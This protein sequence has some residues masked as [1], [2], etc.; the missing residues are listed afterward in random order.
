MFTI[1]LSD[2]AD[3]TMP[4]TICYTGILRRMDLHA[5]SYI[6]H[7]KHRETSQYPAADSHEGSELMCMHGRVE[8]LSSA[9][10]VALLRYLGT[11]QRMRHTCLIRPLSSG[12]VDVWKLHSNPW[13]HIDISYGWWLRGK[14]TY[15]ASEPV[16]QASRSKFHLLY[17]QLLIIEAI[18]EI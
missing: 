11:R 13:V 9:T 6:S 3:R 4:D 16:R 2:A 14:I 12:C 17:L 5:W 7:Q 18:L 1:L 10:T 15:L 8:T